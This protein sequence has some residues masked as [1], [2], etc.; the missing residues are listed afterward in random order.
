M[1]KAKEA[2]SGNSNNQTGGGTDPNQTT[3][4]TGQQAGGQQASGMDQKI[5]SGLTR[6]SPS[7]K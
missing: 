6:R 3:G 5:N 4:A 2:M 1:N 7:K